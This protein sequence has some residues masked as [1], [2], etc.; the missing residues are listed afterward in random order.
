MMNGTNAASPA[1][2]V[3][4]SF[5]VR[6]PD[7]DSLTATVT[8]GGKTVA[9]SLNGPTTVESDYGSLVITPRGGGSNITFDFEYTL[10]EE[11]YSKTDQLAEGEQVTD[12]IVI[13]VNDGMG[14]TVTQKPCK[15]D[16]CYW[17]DTGAVHWGT[18]TILDLSKV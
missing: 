14:H 7:G 11:P 4:G 15:R 13:S 16:N 12:G 3:T 9:V 18:M 8:I 17:I 10:K 6:D 1:P 5:S 2:S